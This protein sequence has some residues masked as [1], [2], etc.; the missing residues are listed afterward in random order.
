MDCSFLRCE[1]NPLITKDDLP[2]RANTVFNAG[3]ADLGDEVVLVMR[4]ESLSGRSHLIVARSEDG[5]TNWRVSD[6]AL[7][8]PDDGDMYEE[9]GVEDC[10]VTYLPDKGVWGLTYTACHCAGHSI[11]VALT[12]DFRNI[13]RLGLAFPS[14][15]KNAVLFPRKINGLYAMLHRPASGGGS[16]WIAYSPDLIYWG[17]SEMVV[18][19]RGGPWWDGLRVGAGV[20]PIE[21]ECGW[22][23]L[24][25][26]VKGMVS[27]PIYRVGAVL[28][29]RENPARMIARSRRWFL[30]PETSYERLGDVGNVV[31]P[32]GGFVRGSE[33]WVYYGAADSSVCLATISVPDMLDTVL[34]EP[35]I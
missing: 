15:N 29:D 30:G 3:A 1:K 33:L 35:V 10:R 8:H 17:R 32:C 12:S 34:S 25:H 27:G 5:I 23:V 6:R 13:E 20:T 24:Y 4:V 11:A 19:P 16:I 7:V 26:G 18:P 9:Y 2:Y 28:L 21:T 22:L 14:D 31:F